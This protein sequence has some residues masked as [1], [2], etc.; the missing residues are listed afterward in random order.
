MNHSEDDII[1]NHLNLP[2]LNSTFKKL[3][4]CAIPT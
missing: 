4:T 3:P 1:A 2:K